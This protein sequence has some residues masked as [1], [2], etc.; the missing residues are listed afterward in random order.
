MRAVPTLNL[1]LSL[2][3]WRSRAV[4]YLLIYA[5]LVVALVS[6]RASTSGV[7]P[8]LREAQAREQQ[9]ITQRDDL[10]L[11]LQVLES[12]PRILAWA[13]ANGMELSADSD[14][15]TADIAGIPEAPLVG[16]RP[17]TVEVITQWK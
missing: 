2:P 7:R 17:G 16:A 13:R 3:T 4:R 5:A 10:A 1:D 8:A 12:R 14:R 9:L 15:G 11:Q 6:V